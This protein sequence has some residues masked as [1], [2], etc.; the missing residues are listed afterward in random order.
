MLSFNQMPSLLE[1]DVNE[2]GELWLQGPN[3]MLRYWKNEESTKN[4]L[5]QDGF[6]KTGRD[7]SASAR[8]LTQLKRPCPLSGDMGYV[9]D[10]GNWFIVDRLKELVKYK[11]FQVAPAELEAIL[12]S[13]EFVADAAVIPA[14]D[15]Q[16][17]EVP[18]AF[19]VLSAT[20]KAASDKSGNE[21]AVIKEIDQFINS[22]V[23][24]YKKLRGGIECIAEI[25]KSPSGKIL[26]R[27]LVEKERAKHSQQTQ[28]K[29]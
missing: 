11:G 7:K 9:D 23:S 22:K 26:R 19:V 8:D 17:C 25:P 14:C 20:G 29:L 5:T 4:T 12:L 2:I 28:A 1:M 24:D 15:A 27:I 13:H 18:K 16:G 6:I 3:V 10:E 21:S